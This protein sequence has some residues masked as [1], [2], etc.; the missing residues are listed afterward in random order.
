[1]AE[2]YVNPVANP[3]Q[4]TQ[5]TTKF[6]DTSKYNFNIEPFLKP[7]DYSGQKAEAKGMVADYGNFINSQEKLGAMRD[8]ISGQLDLPR[9]RETVTRYG[10]VADDLT[11]QLQGMGQQVAGTSRNSLMTQGQRQGV[12]QAKSQPL[13]QNLQQV[14]RL[15]ERAG[16]RL[17]QSEQ[18]LGNRMQ[19]EIAQQQKELLP[20]EKDFSFL[21]QSQAREFA[22]YTFANQLE[23]NRLISNQQAGLK[24]TDSEAERANRLAL[25]EWSY[26]TALDGIRE[27][28]NQARMT[29]KAPSDLASMW[30]A[31]G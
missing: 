1:M 13:L 3:T 26:K 10:E 21:E 11:S 31:M 8:R 17:A 6:G 30:S 19:Q 22:G 4:V 24:W 18:E 5:N 25:A 2:T 27:S 20:W 14:G 15:G 16:A 23:L 7:F 12:V 29:K 28:G 9:Q